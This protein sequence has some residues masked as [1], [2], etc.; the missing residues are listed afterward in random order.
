M[1]KQNLKILVAFDGSD[2]AIEAV[3][4]V[5]LLM[6]SAY[7]EVVL[8]FV[9]NSMSNG[10]LQSNQD[11]DFRFKAA[12]LRACI[13]DQHKRINAAMDKAARFLM[14]AGFPSKAVIKKIQ[15]K[16]LSIVNDIQRESQDGY[17]AVV[18]GRTGESR[19]KDMLLGSVPTK[20]LKKIQGIPMIIVGGTPRENRILV[21]FDGSKEI[22]RAVKAMSNLIGASDCKVSFCH[23]FKPQ[24]VFAK[25]GDIQWKEDERKRIEPTINKAKECLIDSGFSFNQLC[26][27]IIDENGDLATSIINKA[28][29]ENFSTI[30]IG[31]RGLSVYQ[32]FITTRVGEK[33]FK[34]AEHLTVWVFG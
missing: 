24:G 29:E 6:P 32:E 17:D 11:M 7:T 10:F 25:E 13:T 2:L 12:N 3:K 20:L 18:M 23:V 31:R 19:L 15:P 34:Q 21:A 30:V 9:E 8:F 4:Y 22:M 27:E 1:H 5:A 26:C 28:N 16:N 14:E 33:I